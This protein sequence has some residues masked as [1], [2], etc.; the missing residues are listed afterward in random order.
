MRNLGTI[1][2]LAFDLPTCPPSCICRLDPRWKLAALLGAALAAALLQTP[3]AVLLALAGAL[4]L[5]I[6][7]R[8]PLRWFA[9]RLATALVM[10]ALFVCWRPFLPRTGEATVELAGIAVSL[11]GLRLALVLL[12]RAAVL[13]TLML[14]LVAT[15]PLHDT[16]KA[17]H[18]LYVPG[19]LVQLAALSYRYVFLLAEEFSR[20]RIALRVRGFRNRA[21]RRSYQTIG[22]V[23][24][25]LLVRSHERAERVAAAMRCRGFDGRFRSLHTFCTSATDVLAFA[26]I[27]GTAGGLLLWDWYARTSG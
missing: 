21:D 18:S 22:L 2:T 7:A 10:L 23:A 9:L 14:V 16:L 25:T 8:L 4:L 27:T 6:L 17:A 20:L 15:A 11:P 5:A 1:M 24:G 12:V 19:L 13:V 3:T 26:L